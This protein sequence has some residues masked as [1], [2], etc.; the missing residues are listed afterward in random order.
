MP[1]Q[2]ATIVGPLV[3][4]AFMISPV[5]SADPNFEVAPFTQDALP[6]SLLHNPATIK[7]EPAG[8]NK[9]VEI[10]ESDGVPGGQAISM[11]VKRKSK[12]PWDIN[13]RARL[14]KDLASGEKVEIYFWARASKLSKGKEAGRIA[15][16]LNRNREPYDTVIAQDILPTT[17]W[18]MYR[19]SG[20]AATDFPVEESEMGFNFGYTK[21]TI[22]L[23]PFYAV[24][25]GHTDSVE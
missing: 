6:G 8:N 21:Q 24:T 16:A 20:V 25:L 9:R 22:E 17:D 12:E 2:K 5:S 4:G 15:V 18:K 7:W 19:V 11:Q 3:A 13:M 14:D 23:G 1:M 10:V